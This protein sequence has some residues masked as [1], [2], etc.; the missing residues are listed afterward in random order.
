MGLGQGEQGPSEL[1]AVERRGERVGRGRVAGI[2]S[3]VEPDR[4]DRRRR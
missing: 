1:V 3:V 2:R 4:P